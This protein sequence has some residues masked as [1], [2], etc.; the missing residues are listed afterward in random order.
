MGFWRSALSLALRLTEQSLGSD[1]TV[2]REHSLKKESGQITYVGPEASCEMCGETI[3]P[4]RLWQW[5]SA[6][7]CSQDCAE[8]RLRRRKRRRRRG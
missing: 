4:A 6:V 8:T 7:T 1:G 5:P 3:D 2:Y